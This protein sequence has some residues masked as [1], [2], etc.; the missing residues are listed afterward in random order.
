M[1]ANMCCGVGTRGMK[2][3]NQKVNPRTSIANKRNVQQQ[4]IQSSQL[5]KELQE[6]RQKLNNTT[7]RH[8]LIAPFDLDAHQYPPQ[9]ALLENTTERQLE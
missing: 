7:R 4:S 8:T 6:Q 9:T 1:G 3:Q 2:H 5:K